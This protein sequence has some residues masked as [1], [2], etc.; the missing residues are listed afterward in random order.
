MDPL[1]KKRLCKPWASVACHL[2]FSSAMESEENGSFVS[3]A[4]TS[5]EE[6]LFEYVYEYMLEAIVSSQT[7]RIL[8]PELDFDGFRMVMKLVKTQGMVHE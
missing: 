7:A 8:S 3:D 2:D 5:N 6:T 4:N 1:C